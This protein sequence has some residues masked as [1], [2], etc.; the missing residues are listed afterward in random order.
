MSTDNLALYQE[1]SGFLKWLEREISFSVDDLKNKRIIEN[2]QHA[3]LSEVISI[4]KK[5]Q[6][7]IPIEVSSRNFQESVETEFSISC[8]RLRPLSRQVVKTNQ[9]I[10]AIVFKL[11]GMKSGQHEEVKTE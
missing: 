2:Y 10:D 4:L 6:K 5:N 11:Y 8:E 7:M 9:L 3:N 1:K